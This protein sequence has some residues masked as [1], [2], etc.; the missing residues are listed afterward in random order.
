M[1]ARNFLVIAYPPVCCTAL[2]ALLWTT[3]V[4]AATFLADSTEDAVS[5]NPGDG[6][7][8]DSLG[9]CTL[10]AAV[11]EANALGGSHTIMLPAGVYTLAIPGNNEH[12]AATG[13]LDLRTHITVISQDLDPTTT[14]VDGGGLDR[15]FEV[16]DGANAVL[17]HLTI[18][19]GLAGMNALGFPAGGGIA[20]NGNNT[21]VTIDTCIVSGNRAAAYGGGI[22]ITYA[23]ATVRNTTVYMNRADN[24]GGIGLGLAGY[25]E[26]HNST[27]SGNRA[28]TNGG[29][30]LTSNLGASLNNVTIVQNLSNYSNNGIGDGGGIAATYANNIVMRNS[31]VAANN[32][33]YGIDGGV[34]DC[35]TPG[36]N[37]M[38]YNLVGDDTGCNF[39]PAAG[40][41][42]GD[43]LNPVDPGIGPYARKGGPTPTHALRAD[44]PALDAAFPL[45][46]GSGGNACETLDQR[47]LPRIEHGLCDMGAF[48]RARSGQTL[49]VNSA[50]D[51]VDASPG[52]GVCASASGECTLRA[53]IQE[54]NTLLTH[55]TVVVPAGTYLLTLPGASEDNAATGDL[56]INNDL[57]MLGAGP[58]ESVIDGGALDRV[59][60]VRNGSELVITGITVRNGNDISGN[61]GGGIYNDAHG[62]LNISNCEVADNET[63][64]SG[65]GIFSLAWAELTVT[66][67]EV[68]GNLAGNYGGGISNFTM[69]SAIVSNTTIRD[70]RAQVGGGFMN[71]FM[72]DA[73]ITA[74][75][76]SNNEATNSGGGI[77]MLFGNGSLSLSNSTLSGNL[78]GIGGGGGLSSTNSD[79]VNLRNVT[80][81]GNS[82]RN[83]NGGG[84]F[85]D[86]VVQLRNSIIAGNID[87]GGEAPDCDTSIISEGYN[88]LGNDTGCTYLAEDG[89]LVGTG[90][91]PLAPLLSPLADNGGPTWT[92]NPL[93]GSPVLDAGNPA[94]PGG[95]GMACELADQRGVARTLGTRCDM[96]AVEWMPPVATAVDPPQVPA[97]DDEPGEGVRENDDSGTSPPPPVV[98]SGSGGAGYAS[99][100]PAQ[101]EVVEQ[102]EP[103]TEAEP[104]TEPESSPEEDSPPAEEPATPDPQDGADQA[105]QSP[106]AAASAASVNAG[107]PGAGGQAVA[108]PSGQAMMQADVITAGVSVV[109][110]PPAPLAASF[111]EGL[112]KVSQDLDEAAREQ[113]SRELLISGTVKGAGLLLLA[114]IT[115][116][117]LKAAT[118]LASLL[119]ALPLWMRFDPLPVLLVSE[120]ERRRREDEARRMRR[121]EDHR[122]RGIGRLLDSDAD[123]THGAGREE[124]SP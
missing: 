47:G 55:E 78:G 65:G 77:G 15:V 82:S 58:G 101:E 69:A 24:G 13:D 93:S 9:R 117:Y 115:N 98:D 81:T 108:A 74:S 33:I 112:D 79:I 116:W 45:T 122:H 72:S 80:I 39:V 2:C 92:H 103:D 119:T 100:P 29:G 1:T 104:G 51:A 67:C 7:C 59:L 17:S 4:A 41:I 73:I 123:V 26:I 75:T 63:P 5:A 111:W 102:P 60:H 54:A 52:D 89:D 57:V 53:A 86:G 62:I 43:G 83:G 113:E 114:G 88:L 124:S 87:P 99:Q 35:H 118:L 32:G 12:F 120:Q 14:I 71:S 64:A 46:P 34:R 110:G 96:G 90:A 68:F 85:G 16:T 49:V 21:R 8:A 20:A 105:D 6:I 44:S 3:P 109:A 91:N 27:L 84:V 66:D 70:N 22:D 76:L 106:V 121:A 95:G 19:N 28:D 56:D 97:P 48:Q 10:R 50:V 18:R 25:V 94:V 42:V 31:I 40:D 11:Q 107:A 36:L 37:S 38:G 30:L 23:N 61:G